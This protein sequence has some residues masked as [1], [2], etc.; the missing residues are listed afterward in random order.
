MDIKFKLSLNMKNS[1]SNSIKKFS[2]TITKKNIELKSGIQFLLE[3]EIIT[4]YFQPIIVKYCNSAGVNI[5]DLIVYSYDVESKTSDVSVFFN[6]E[7]I[8]R[9]SLKPSIYA[10]SNLN[11]S[12]MKLFCEQIDNTSIRWYWD[13]TDK[14]S[15][16]L[17]KENN[18]VKK[19]IAGIN[20][21]IESDLTPNK[22]YSRKININ[23]VESLICSLTLKENAKTSVYDHF[24]VE[25]RD[26]TI[27]ITNDIYSSRLKAF[28]SGVGDNLSCKLFKQIDTDYGKKFRL[29]NRIYGVRASNTIKHHTTKFK[30]RYKMTGIINYPSYDGSAKVNISATPLNKDGSVAGDKITCERTLDYTFDTSTQV[31]DIHIIDLIPSLVQDYSVQYSINVT[32]TDIIGELSVYSHTHGYRKNIFNGSQAIK[33]SEKGYYDYK[34][35]ISS[36]MVTKSKEYIDIYPPNTYEPLVGIVNGD[37][38]VSESGKKDMFSSAYVFSPPDSV[39]NKKYYCLIEDVKPDSSYV[40]YKFENET[41]DKDYTVTNGDSIHFSSDAVV[42]ND[43]EYRDF[44][45]QVEEGEYYINDSKK[46]V[47]NYTLNDLVVNADRYKRFELVVIGSSSDINILEHT[48]MLNVDE[49]NKINTDIKVVIRAVQNAVARWQPLIHNGHYYYNQE[50]RFLYT[51]CMMDGENKTLDNVFTKYPIGI[52]VSVIASDNPGPIEYYDIRKFQKSDLWINRT[53]YFWYKDKIWPKP[54]HVSG[55]YYDFLDEY[56]YES[57]PFLFNKRPTNLQSI[58]WDQVCTENN[59]IDVYAISYNEIFGEWNKPVK[60]EYNGSLPDGIKLSKIL[61]LRYVLKPSR[62]PDLVVDSNLLSCENHW[63]SCCDKYLSHNIYYKK[64]HLSSKSYKTN[65]I[66]ISNMYD[67][68]DT[69]LKEKQR[70]IMLNLNYVG[71]VDIFIQHSD[72]KNDLENKIDNSTWLSAANNIPYV[73]LKRYCR[74]KIEIK[75]KSKIHHMNLTLTRYEYDD[76]YDKFMPSFGN[77]RV[78]AEY[79]PVLSKNLYE[80][81]ISTNLEFDSEEHIIIPD[82]YEFVEGMAIDQNFEIENILEHSISSYGQLKDDFV[83][84][85]TQS[86]LTNECVYIQSKYIKYDLDL[87]VKNQNGVVFDIV[88]NRLEVSPIPQQYSPIIITEEKLIYTQITSND[89]E[90]MTNT[91]FINENGEFTLYN[92]EKFESL[93]FKTLYLKYTDIDSSSINIEINGVTIKEYSA[94]NNIIKFNTKIPKDYTITVRYKLKNSYCV[95]YDYENDKAI[96]NFN[97]ENGSNIE[98][99]RIFYETNKESSIRKLDN[100]NLNPI[101]NLAYSGYIYICD[102]SLNPH[103]VFIYPA[104]NS[105]YANGKDDMIVIVVVKDKNNNPVENADVNIVCAYGTIIKENPTTDNNGIIPCIYKSTTINCIDTIK[106]TASPTVKAKSTIINRKL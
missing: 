47:Y 33:F 77:I 3:N 60:L 4:S 1:V 21:Y 11:K 72:T 23:G 62:I 54:V 64:E 32:I 89:I 39:Y 100:I 5:N 81:V 105:I 51:S 12:E 85:Y 75:N 87:M 95:N 30:Y 52:K 27:F 37:F 94:I 49:N 73:S 70:S 28:S 79:N 69:A 50:E 48:K 25:D 66:Y 83:I 17:N 68:G 10:S 8:N 36:T 7:D 58:T 76:N 84:R 93:G 99:I 19:I 24:S 31:A 29:L 56:V 26:E 88:D 43:I 55:N 71:E 2:K 9:Y 53:L 6:T 101:Y 102:Y 16:I 103:S 65:G 44:L 90:P 98:K 15:V 91:F 63:D 57:E 42:E 106:V 45:A 34:F 18:I 38:E 61:K 86:Q 67:L 40:K 92:E 14:E 82:L 13:E 74:F 20:Y 96:I 22:T 46:H 35:T 78:N 80:K 104:S 59:Y 97:K 41:D